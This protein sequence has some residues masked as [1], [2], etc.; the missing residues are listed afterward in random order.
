MC[1][2]FTKLTDNVACFG[3]VLERRVLSHNLFSSFQGRKYADKFAE[4]L[5]T[6]LPE[7]T[8]LKKLE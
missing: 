4:K 6:I 7:F 8:V 1:L 5:S 3:L 2:K